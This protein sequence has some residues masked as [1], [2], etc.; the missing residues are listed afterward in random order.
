MDGKIYTAYPMDAEAVQG[1]ADKF[2]E[3]MGSPVR[4]K[5]ELD[6]SLIAGFIVQIGFLRFDYSARARLKEMTRHMLEDA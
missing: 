2:T 5:Q 6:A 3:R 1:I 4:L